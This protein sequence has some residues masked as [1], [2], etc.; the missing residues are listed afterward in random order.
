MTLS[1][2]IESLPTRT[3]ATG[4]SGLPII[5]ILPEIRKDP[6]ATS[7]VCRVSTKMWFA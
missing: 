1:Q 5:G 2:A 6:F 7:F 3:M 4:P